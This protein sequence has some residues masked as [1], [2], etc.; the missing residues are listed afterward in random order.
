MNIT[1]DIV[2]PLKFLFADNIHLNIWKSNQILLDI[3]FVKLA[4]LKTKIIL[5]CVCVWKCKENLV[6]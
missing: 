4:R 5:I 2:N 1:L 3:A 6:H